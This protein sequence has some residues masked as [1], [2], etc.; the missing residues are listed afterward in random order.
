M[1]FLFML[2]RLTSQIAP[3]LI[4]RETREHTRLLAVGPHAQACLRDCSRTITRSMDVFIEQF[5]FAAPP[6]KSC[7][8]LLYT[9]NTLFFSAPDFAES[10]GSPPDQRG[11]CS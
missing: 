1:S 3:E 6:C 7:E 5:P 4:S 10:E 8:G 9:L 11:L 2:F